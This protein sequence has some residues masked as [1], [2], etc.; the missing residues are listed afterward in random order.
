MQEHRNRG[1]VQKC[2]EASGIFAHQAKC[3]GTFV[4][5]L[6]KHTRRS[7]IMEG[8]EILQIDGQN[9]VDFSEEGL[10]AKFQEEGFDTERLL[11]YPNR[12]VTAGNDIRFMA[13]CM[14]AT[15][16]YATKPQRSSTVFVTHSIHETIKKNDLLYS[17]NDVLCSSMTQRDLD[18]AFLNRASLVVSNKQQCLKANKIYADKD[19]STYQKKCFVQLS[20]HEDIFIGDTVEELNGRAAQSMTN[21]E[22]VQALLQPNCGIRTKATGKRPE[23]IKSTIDPINVDAALFQTHYDEST[24]FVMCAVCALEDSPTNMRRIDCTI[25]DLLTT[26]QSAQTMVVNTLRA[27]SIQYD[28]IYAEVLHKE[29]PQGWLTEASHVC[30]TCVNQME[31]PSK[32]AKQ[33]EKLA[34]TN[35][36]NSGTSK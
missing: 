18:C 9:A 24:Q 8:D 35:S 10:F 30:L 19:A 23:V 15:G 5:V 17:I 6:V 33:I 2:L 27:S 3:Q 12:A 32:R 16:L 14:S 34:A 25:K 4:K 11:L 1:V 28:Q 36:C 22:I 29:L 31:E 26:I 21:V 7:N 20:V 13:Q